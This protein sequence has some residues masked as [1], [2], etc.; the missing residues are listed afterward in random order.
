MIRTDTNTCS[1]HQMHE[2]LPRKGGGVWNQSTC[3]LISVRLSQQQ[4]CVPLVA[5]GIS[6]PIRV[7]YL[8]LPCN[9]YEQLNPLKLPNRLNGF[10][11]VESKQCNS[12]KIFLSVCVFFSLGKSVMYLLISHPPH[13]THAHQVKSL[14]HRFPSVPFQPGNVC[15]LFA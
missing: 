13:K 2:C 15:P 4:G 8:L 14:S 10:N 5:Q 1:H 9:K 7:S 12:I 11:T 6:V 3:F